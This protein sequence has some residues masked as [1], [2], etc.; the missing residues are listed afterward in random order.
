MVVGLLGNDLAAGYAPSEV[1]AL[2]ARVMEY[3]RKD[4][5]GIKLYTYNRLPNVRTKTANE[6]RRAQYMEFNQLIK[7]YCDKHDDVTLIDFL[8]FPALFQEGHVGDYEYQRPELYVEDGAH[9][10]QTG[11]DVYRDIFLEVLDDIL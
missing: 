2:L 3:A 9:F 4:F 5:P 8:T 6:V 10:N 1:V 11:Y 7:E